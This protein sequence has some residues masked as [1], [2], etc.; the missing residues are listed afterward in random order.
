MNNLEHDKDCD[1]CKIIINCGGGGDKH[2]DCPAPEF[3]EVYST[4][5][6]TLSASPGLNMAGQIVILENTIFATS[7]IDL[8][9]SALNGKV[10]INRAGWYDVYTGMCGALN[11]ISSPLPV[12]TLSLFKNGVIVPGSTF[13]NMT[14]SPEQKSNEVVADVFVHC[15]A[16][17]FLELANTSSAQVE[18]TAPS[19]GTNAQTNSA[20]LKVVLLQAD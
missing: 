15:D 8:S 5:A 13:A 9:Q 18:L 20:Y 4:T 16:G 11:P 6:Q 3:A 19:L 17:D 12:W 2:C 10:I 14:L 7:N 1:G